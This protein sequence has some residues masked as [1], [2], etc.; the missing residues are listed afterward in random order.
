QVDVSLYTFADLTIVYDGQLHSVTVSNL[1]A[2]VTVAYADNTLT[3]AGVKTA[4]VTFAL[5]DTANY[6]FKDSI[7]TKTAILTVK[8]AEVDVHTFTFANLTT[9]YD[10]TEHK[11]E[12][13]NISPLVTVSYYNNTLTNAGE[14]RAEAAFTLKDTANYAFVNNTD[15]LT[16]RLKVEPR[17]VTVTINDVTNEYGKP[18]IPNLPYVVSDNVIVGDDLKIT[19]FTEVNIYSIVGIY[20]ISGESLNRNYK[21]TFVGQSGGVK[22]KY[23]VIMATPTYTAPTFTNVYIGQMMADSML[24]GGVGDGA[25][26]IDNKVSF[27]SGVNNVSVTFKPTNTNYNSVTF[28]VSVTP[29]QLYVTL[30]DDTQVDRKIAVAY[31]GTLDKTA[32]VP[33]ARTGYSVAWDNVVT[34]NITSDIT[35]TAVYTANTYAITYDLVGG[36][37]GA[38]A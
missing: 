15:G 5:I 23:T 34:A 12:A 21:V 8:K 4:S 2:L 3:N 30:V 17:K 6:E 32:Y 31:G 16:A 1:D 7:N 14:I 11:L 28:N 18:V 10:G 38:S 26:S 25:F 29:I 13:S 36:V 24:I 35:V 22:G 33:L 37:S 20:D 19:L 27:V 9:T